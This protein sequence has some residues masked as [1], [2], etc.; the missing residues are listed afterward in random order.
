M[1]KTANNVVSTLLTYL[2][3]FNE[4]PATMTITRAQHWDLIDHKKRLRH[5]HE[6]IYT[7]GKGLVTHFRQVPVKVIG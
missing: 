3:G 2:A 6:L 1:A 5:A 7:D 4:P